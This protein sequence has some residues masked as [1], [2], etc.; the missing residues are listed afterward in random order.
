MPCIPLNN[1]RGRAT[2]VA[3]H[4]RRRGQRGA[5]SLCAACRLGEARGGTPEKVMVTV[6]AG[7]Q[8]LFRV[9]LRGLINEEL[10]G[11]S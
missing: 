7:V 10:M 9:L 2:L 11:S 6:A 1:Y 3:V 4:Q 8:D 5:P